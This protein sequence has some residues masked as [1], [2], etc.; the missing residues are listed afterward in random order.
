MGRGALSLPREDGSLPIAQDFTF[1]DT[2]P[3]GK[4][5]DTRGVPCYS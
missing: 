4:W 2:T 3:V 5:G 1:S